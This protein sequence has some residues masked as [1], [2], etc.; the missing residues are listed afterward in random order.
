M[1]AKKKYDM[2]ASVYDLIETK[3]KPFSEY[4]K[5][6]A[7]YLEG[8]VL[9]LGI[10]SGANLEYYPEN[11]EVTGVDFSEKML[12]KCEEKRKSLCLE[13]VELLKIDVEDMDFEDCSFDIVYSTF[14]FCTV[15]HPEKGLGEAYRVLKPS[16]KAVFIEHMKSKH[17]L[18]NGILY[19]MNIFSKLILGTSMLRETE[20]NIK[21][22]GFK[23][24][25]KKELFF[26]IVRL[27][28][29]EK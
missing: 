21:K 11:I 29:V 19:C 4:R 15:P 12:E 9:E 7:N 6:G 5:I 28:V 22:S 1:N 18:L 8:K 17:L 2:L 26:D 13:G 25:E 20:E 10:G 24:I 16:G 14:V 3:I 23:I 27:I